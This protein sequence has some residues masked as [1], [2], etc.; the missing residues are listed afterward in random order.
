MKSP[1]ILRSL[2]NVVFGIGMTV[3]CV[4]ASAPVFG[5][6]EQLNPPGGPESATESSQDAFAE[7]VQR[8]SKPADSGTNEKPASTLIEISEEPKTVD[9]ATLV[10]K[11][12]AV[13][14]TVKFDAKPLRDIVKWLQQDQ[15]LNVLI[16][17]A[18]L[19]EEGLLIGEPVTD[20]SV[21]APLY[22]LLNRLSSI[23]LAWYFEDD[24][25][26]VTTTARASEHLTTIPYLLGDLFDKGYKPLD[27]IRTIIQ[28]TG[29]QWV[30]IDGE[31]GTTV[32]LGD[33]LF[34]RQTDR[35]QWEAAGLLASLRKHGRKTFTFDPEQHESLRQKLNVR[36]TVD[37][38]EIPLRDA[39]EALA[40]QSGADI[41]I[42]TASLS[43]EGVSVRSPVTLKMVD[44]PLVSVLRALELK[45]G[46]TGI[47]RDGVLWITTRNRA[48][49]FF[50]TAVFDVRDLCRNRH[51]STELM[52]A[53]VT[54]VHGAWLEVDGD[55][56][57]MISP[58]PGVLVVRQTA[59]PLDDL[60]KLLESYRAALLISKPR[61]NTESDP[62]EMVTRYYRM[63]REVA[64]DL[65]KHL[66]ELVAPETWKSHER[67]DANGTIRCIASDAG[68]LDSG[69]HNAH[70]AAP[71]GK[72]DTLVVFNSVLII[73]QSREIHDSITK[74]IK[75]IQFGDAEIYG[76]AGSGSGG[77]LGGSSGSMGGGGGLGGASQGG[78][79]GGFGGGFFSIPGR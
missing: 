36:V 79:Q 48:D 72:V 67:P 16:D 5:Q 33:V 78:Q 31:G 64:F 49:E 17:Q 20:E 22:L 75:R 74:V 6:V 7:Q 59:Q 4:I 28:V 77:P 24:T 21:D 42:E 23:N 37:F 41:R 68:L 52:R 32:L 27:L 18:A 73:H 39:V 15:G 45:L 56:G 14:V 12:L 58:K 60:S 51:E 10:P 19:A 44:R 1:R 46:L 26:Y 66:A 11:P 25:L 63:Q 35:R 13:H 29:G 69:G 53:L 57:T 76:S 71:K 8:A 55:G 62:K 9:P 30:T 50:Q 3:V 54:Q 38:E 2:R 70:S 65:E 40:R 34:I 61:E 43:D 47:L